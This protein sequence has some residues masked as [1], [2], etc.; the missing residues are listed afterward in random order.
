MY[1]T[2]PWT[3]IGVLRLAHLHMEY[4]DLCWFRSSP[5]AGRMELGE[6]VCGF[7]ALTCITGFLLHYHKKDILSFTV[8]PYFLLT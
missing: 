2:G 8:D 3:L 4:L 7:R 1:Y 5:K 6:C